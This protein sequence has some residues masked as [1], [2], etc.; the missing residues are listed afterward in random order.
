MINPYLTPGRA[1]LKF[2]PEL[3]EKPTNSAHRKGIVDEPRVRAK[4]QGG[5]LEGS[6]ELR[7]TFSRK[8]YQG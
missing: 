8:C 7:N 6:L 1:T 5:I 3:V 4:E 2:G